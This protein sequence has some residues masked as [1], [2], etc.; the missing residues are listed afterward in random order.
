MYHMTFVF[1]DTTI[2][3]TMKNGKWQG[4]C[5]DTLSGKSQDFTWTMEEFTAIIALALN[6]EDMNYRINVRE[7]YAI[8]EPLVK[9]W[10]VEARPIP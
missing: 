2:I 1:C 6:G 7:C 3:A 9:D 8:A 10:P 5:Y 4:T